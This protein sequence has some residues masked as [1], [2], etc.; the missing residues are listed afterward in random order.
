MG[1][2]AE[3]E[4]DFVVGREWDQAFGRAVETSVARALKV[5]RCSCCGCDLAVR[6][7]QPVTPPAVCILCADLRLGI[8]DWGVDS[9]RPI[10][11]L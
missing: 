8:D 3:V 7:D 10:L 9:P 6:E 5:T 1:R 4:T 11:G 2:M